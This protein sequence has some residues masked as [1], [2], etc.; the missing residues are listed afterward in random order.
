MGRFLHGAFLLWAQENRCLICTP[1][2]PLLSIIPLTLQSFYFECPISLARSAV[3]VYGPIEDYETPCTSEW[4]V[5]VLVVGVGGEVGR[6]CRVVP[7][8]P[9][10]RYTAWLGLYRMVRNKIIFFLIQG[11]Q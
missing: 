8:L 6:H 9:R 5:G 10:V 4:F 3:M 1:M 7:E 2:D 11:F